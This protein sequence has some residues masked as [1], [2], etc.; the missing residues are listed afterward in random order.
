M[1]SAKQTSIG[2]KE[3]EKPTGNEI[4]DALELFDANGKL[5]PSLKKLA[6]KGNKRMGMNPHTFEQKEEYITFTGGL[7]KRQDKDSIETLV[8]RADSSAV[9][10]PV[11]EDRKPKRAIERR[12]QPGP[13]RGDKRRRADLE[14]SPAGTAPG[15]QRSV[16]DPVRLRV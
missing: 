1:R 11:P 7:T 12:L 6:P 10:D 8:G 4:K 2:V 9:P 3:E 15:K 14:L 5:I 13:E 16:G